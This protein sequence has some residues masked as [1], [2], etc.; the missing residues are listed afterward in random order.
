MNIVIL[1]NRDLASNV[2]LN[3]LL[4]ALHDHQCY[5]WLSSKVGGNGSKPPD[6]QRLTFFEQS[7]PN[8]V[9]EPLLNTNAQQGKFHSFD[10]LCRYLVAPPKVQNNANSEESLAELNALKPDLIICIRYGC[11]LKSDCIN[12]PEFGVINLHSG[13]LPD[14][15]GVMATFWAMLRGEKQIGTTLHTIDDNSIDTGRIIRISRQD[16]KPEACY[17]ENVLSLY[18]QGAE[19]ILWAVNELNTSGKLACSAQPPGGNYFTFPSE[20]DLQAF[21]A[22]GMSLVNESFYLDVM[23]RYY[24][25]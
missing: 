17:L 9:I 18:R 5:L 3:Q 10:G 21:K 11:I 19:D 8:Q 12:R 4:P 14:Y 7:L 20:S 2:A 25:Q 6:L 22:K 24:V 16:T 23:R 13:V 15:R 1:S